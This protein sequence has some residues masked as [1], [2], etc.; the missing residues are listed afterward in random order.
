MILV[1]WVPE[2]L[3][4]FREERAVKTAR[5]KIRTSG[6]GGLESHFH[7]NLAKPVFYSDVNVVPNSSPLGIER[8]IL[9]VPIVQQPI[10]SDMKTTTVGGCGLVFSLVTS[11][12]LETRYF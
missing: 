12:L 2:V 3:F 5:R 6:H 8:L 11:F 1:P 4:F 10:K 9:T 7:A